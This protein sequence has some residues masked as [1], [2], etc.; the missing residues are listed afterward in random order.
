MV[1]DFTAFF[2]RI[3]A[4]ADNILFRRRFAVYLN[5][6]SYRTLTSLIGVPLLDRRGM[7]E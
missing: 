5:I 2:L 7:Y 6:P 1:A 3:P 4:P